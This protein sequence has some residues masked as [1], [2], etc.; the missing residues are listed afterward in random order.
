VSNGKIFS[1]RL[2][3]RRNRDLF[4]SVGLGLEGVRARNPYNPAWLN[5]TDMAERNILSG[6]KVEIVSDHGRIQAI[7]KEDMTV[8]P[9]VVMISHGWGGL[10][11]EN[12]SYETSGSCTNLLVDTETNIE[13]ITSMVRMSSI[14]VNIRRLG[15]HPEGDEGADRQ[16]E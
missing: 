6:D 5:P 3:V 2:A 10:P 7:V 4:N 8:R 9:G 16:S 13:P 15:N 12:L 11:E 14:P 1:H